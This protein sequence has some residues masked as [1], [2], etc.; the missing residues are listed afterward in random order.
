MFKGDSADTCAGK[1][2]LVSMGG[3]ADPSS[4]RGRGTRTPI[5]ESGNFI[6]LII[7]VYAVLKGAWQKNFIPNICTESPAPGVEEIN[8]SK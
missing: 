2:P 3:R 7:L 1:F 6:L 4:M 5:G 8:Y